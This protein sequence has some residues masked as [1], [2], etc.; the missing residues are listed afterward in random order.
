MFV[1]ASADAKCDKGSY[2]KSSNAANTDELTIL[3][4]RPH[5]YM[6]CSQFNGLH[7]DTWALLH[8]QSLNPYKKYYVSNFL[9]GR[10][11]K[12]TINILKIPI[13]SSY[14]NVISVQLSLIL[15]LS[16]TMKKI[17]NRNFLLF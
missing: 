8:L 6:Q 7:Y 16:R 4:F 14:E 1:Y 10:T 3:C 15:P 9:L 5:F 11:K 2:N 17:L 13:Q 12:I